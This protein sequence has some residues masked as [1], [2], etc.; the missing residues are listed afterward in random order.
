MDLQLTGKP[1]WHRRSRGIG[2][3]IALAFA[4]EGARVAICS[5]GEAGLLT[6]AEE[7]R[8]LGAEC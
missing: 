7:I 4:A 5:R 6:A 1:S 2:R 3:Q 8:A